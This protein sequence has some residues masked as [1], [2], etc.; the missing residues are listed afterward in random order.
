[1]I[2]TLPDRPIHQW[3]IPI[4]GF[5]QTHARQTGIGKLWLKMRPLST[6]ENC[7][8]MPLAWNTNWSN[9]ANF[10]RMQSTHAPDIRVYAYSWGCGWGFQNLSKHLDLLGLNV[11]HAVLCDPVFRSKILP[12]WLTFN[13]L[14]MIRGARIKID[15]CVEHV[16]WLRQFKNRPQGANL[17]AVNDR[18]TKIDEPLVLELPHAEMEDSQEFHA[19]V[20][21]TMALPK[22]A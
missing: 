16:R 6:P 15:H 22:G 12:A 18:M 4:M 10:I 1:M 7:V 8:M 19:M 5:T 9:I 20:L 14:S 13:P 3:H 21:E 2:G 11:A 17:V